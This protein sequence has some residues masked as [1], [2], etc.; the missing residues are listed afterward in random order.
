MSLA[1]G[2]LAAFV[3]TVSVRNP[4][5]GTAVGTA[6]LDE[7]L[8][9]PLW[10]KVVAY[11]RL[12]CSARRGCRHRDLDHGARQSGPERLHARSDEV[13]LSPQPTP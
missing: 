4:L 1:T 6:L 13:S 11:S 9:D 7:R 12:G 10:H 2:K 3:A 8:A 5:V